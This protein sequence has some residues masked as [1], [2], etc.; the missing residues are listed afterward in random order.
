MERRLETKSPVSR[1]TVA[2]KLQI[3]PGQKLLLVNDPEDYSKQLS[4]DLPEDT[5][6][7]NP[8]SSADVL[9]VFVRSKRNEGTASQSEKNGF[10]E[11]NYLSYISKG[12]LEYEIRCQSGRYPLLCGENRVGSR[13]HIFGR[14]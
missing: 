14:R 10:T 9:Q 4:I 13:R 2:Q 6:F 3:K 5:L 11:R 7:T 8:G 12:Q 1:K